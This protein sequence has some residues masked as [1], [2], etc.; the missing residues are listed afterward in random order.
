MRLDGAFG[1]VQLLGDAGVGTAGGHQGKDLPFA[2]GQRVDPDT[3]PARP[4]HH[5][6]DHHRID[7]G[8]ARDHPLDV[9]QQ[10]LTIYYR[11]EYR[12]ESLAAGRAVP[13][14]LRQDPHPATRATGQPVR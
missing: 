10:R 9:F 1:E 12:V 13:M 11:V 14:P 2:L 4:G 7:G 6:V 8:A 3:V 5:P